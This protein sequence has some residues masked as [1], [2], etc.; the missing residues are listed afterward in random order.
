MVVLSNDAYRLL[1]FIK[2]SLEEVAG[3]WLKATNYI[4]YTQPLDWLEWCLKHAK[5]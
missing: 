3:T 4:R 1:N 5:F 2:Y